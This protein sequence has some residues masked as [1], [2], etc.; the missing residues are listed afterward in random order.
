[1]TCS[2]MLRPHDYFLSR[3]SCRLFVLASLYHH[4]CLLLPF[5][6]F[7]LAPSHCF[8]LSFVFNACCN[9]GKRKGNSPKLEF[10][11]PSWAL[12]GAEFSYTTSIFVMYGVVDM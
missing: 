3:V 6:I 10:G 9:T 7:G 2:D 4:P 8:A 12:N 11:W 5:L 1:M